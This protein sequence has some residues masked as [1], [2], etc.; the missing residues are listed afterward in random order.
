MLNVMVQRGHKGK[1]MKSKFGLSAIIFVV[2]VSLAPLSG[3]SAQRTASAPASSASMAPAPAPAARATYAKEIKTQIVMYCWGLKCYKYVQKIYW[4]YDNSAFITVVGT[5]KGV[6]YQSRWAYYGSDPIATAGGIGKIY[7]FLWTEGTFY[8][9]ST[10]KYAYLNIMQQVFAD[11]TWWK[12]KFY[13][14]E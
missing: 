12:Y 14:K 1:H 4:Q 9:A 10:G 3:V 11:G 13:Y 5:R 7:Y 8:K 6:V 2:V